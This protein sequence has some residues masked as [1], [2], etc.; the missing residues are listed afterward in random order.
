M[1]QIILAKT[2]GR[3]VCLRSPISSIVV[4]QEVFVLCFMYK[5]QFVFSE[6]T[7]V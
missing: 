1:H 3:M 6:I 2:H 7:L 4:Y 5:L